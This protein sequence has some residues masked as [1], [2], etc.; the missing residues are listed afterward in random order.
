[1]DPSLA[2]DSSLNVSWSR[3]CNDGSAET[4]ESYVVKWSGGHSTNQTVVPKNTTTIKIYDLIPNTNYSIT[5]AAKSVTET[6]GDESEQTTGT[7]S[8]ETQ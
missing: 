3:P 2:T 4:V 6:I 7:T 8:K 1:M 5:V